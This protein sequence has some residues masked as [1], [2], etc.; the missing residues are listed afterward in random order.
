MKASLCFKDKRAHMKLVDAPDN[1]TAEDFN[2]MFDSLVEEFVA[3]ST[4]V[5]YEDIAAF[6]YTIANAKEVASQS[7][8]YSPLRNTVS[9]QKL[10][11][12]IV[13][14]YTGM[15]E[16]WTI[17]FDESKGLG[18]RLYAESESGDASAGAFLDLFRNEILGLFG[19]CL[20]SDEINKTPYME[21]MLGSMV[22]IRLMRAA[23]EDKASLEGL[24]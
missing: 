11:E 4:Q 15:S 23:I 8:S 22:T 18:Q 14:T 13:L 5:G 9:G 24:V 20:V 16:E 21:A 1:I 12:S 2:E 17:F 6:C 19:S 10:A 7:Y 3:G